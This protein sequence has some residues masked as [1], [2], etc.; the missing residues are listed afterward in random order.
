MS[1]ATIRSTLWAA[2][3][4]Y[5]NPLVAAP[6]GWIGAQVATARQQRAHVSNMLTIA[7]PGPL[8]HQP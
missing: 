7:T 5:G 6:A 1:S 3:I 2:C 4:L 8:I